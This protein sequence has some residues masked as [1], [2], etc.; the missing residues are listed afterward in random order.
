MGVGAILIEL[1][2]CRGYG[3]DLRLYRVRRVIM[4]KHIDIK[5]YMC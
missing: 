4:A 5:G 3:L 2:S 1:I